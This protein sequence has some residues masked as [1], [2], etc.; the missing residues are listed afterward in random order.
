MT[1][2]EKGVANLYLCSQFSSYK[3]IYVSRYHAGKRSWIQTKA[4]EHLSQLEMPSSRSFM[5]DC[6]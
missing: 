1:D 4:I 3:I 2:R 5:V 6:E